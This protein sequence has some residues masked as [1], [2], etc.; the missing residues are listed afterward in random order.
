MHCKA[1]FLHF[2][3]KFDFMFFDLMLFESTW[4]FLGY[5]FLGNHM[6]ATTTTPHPPDKK[7]SEKLLTPFH[8][9]DFFDEIHIKIKLVK[10][11]SFL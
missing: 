8:S 7:Y 3:T 6:I 1:T 5:C 11:K 2:E 10:I 4:K 9:E